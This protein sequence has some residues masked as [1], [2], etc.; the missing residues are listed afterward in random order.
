MKALYLLFHGFAPYSG[1]TKKIKY[2]IS[3]LEECG[4]DVEIC[5]MTIDEN[6]FQKRIFGDK[7]ID[8]YG[9]GYKAKFFKWIHFSSLTE[10]ILKSDIKFIYIRSFYNTNPPL[11]RMLKKLHAMGIK[12]V[13]EIPTYPY[14]SEFRNSPLKDKLRGFVNRLYRKELKR[15]IYRIVT[16]TDCPTIHGIK[17]INISNGIDFDSIKL[18]TIVNNTSSRFTLIGVADIHYWHGFD[19][20]I[21]GLYEYYKNPQTVDVFFNIVGEGVETEVAKMKSLTKKYGLEKHIEFLGN[22][23][24]DDLDNLFEKSDFGIASLGRHRSGITSI[25]TLK[26]REYAARGLP[27]IYSEIDDDFE[28][29]PYIIKADPDESPINVKRILQFYKNLALTPLEI[30][31]SIINTLSWSVQMRKVVRETFSE[32]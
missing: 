26:N 4:F 17:T 6:G 27:F 30:R 23:F 32:Q 16:F 29:M 28:R 25:K 11:L 9:N 14:D 22:S 3:A 13:M 8:N 31:N 5:Y 24:G 1:I 12:I 19:R 7:V 18:K 21:E 10:E 2:Q 15:Y 20:V